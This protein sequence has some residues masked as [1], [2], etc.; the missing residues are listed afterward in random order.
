MS[1]K[2]EKILIIIAHRN[3]DKSFNHRMAQEAEKLLLGKGNEVKIVDLHKIKF[4]PLTGPNDFKTLKNP[5]FFDY[6][7]LHKDYF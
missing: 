4:N 5:S 6:Q 3:T 1:T 2:K 7:V